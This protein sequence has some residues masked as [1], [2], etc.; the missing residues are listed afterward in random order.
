MTA[1]SL[2]EAGAFG[3]PH[4]IKGEIYAAIDFE[5]IEP[6]EGDFVFA[7]IDGIEVPFRVLSVRTKGSGYLLSLK[8]ISDEKAAA[9]L[10]NKPL[11]LEGIEDYTPDD[12][13]QIYLEDLIGFRITDNGQSIGTISDYTEPTAENP[14]FVVTRPSGNT[15]LL[16]AAGEL[17][18]DIDFDNNTV[19]MD[20]PVGLLDIN[21]NSSD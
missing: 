16:P 3:K 9:M 20:L 17:I 6:A 8:G 1:P 12:S 21:S 4:G 7:T 2:T 11:L 15:I 14:L 13:E 10:A 5:G 18:N 19:E